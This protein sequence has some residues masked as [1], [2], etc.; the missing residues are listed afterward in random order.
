MAPFSYLDRKAHLSLQPTANLA[1][2][3]LFMHPTPLV[4]HPD[5]RGMRGFLI[6]TLG[7]ELWG[8]PHPHGGPQHQQGQGL[9]L[10]DPS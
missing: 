3:P 5:Q 10:E 2:K 4:F 1:L 7:P 8:H 9:I 6:R